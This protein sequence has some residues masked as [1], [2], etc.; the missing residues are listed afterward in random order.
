MRN[1]RGGPDRL[2]SVW[3]ADKKAFNGKQKVEQADPKMGGGGKN[4]PGSINLRE[5]LPACSLPAQDV[6]CSFL[7]F[8][9]DCT[10]PPGWRCII[11]NASPRS[12]H[13][14]TCE[15]TQSFFPSAPLLV[16]VNMLAVCLCA[17]GGCV[18]LSF[19][20]FS[21]WYTFHRSPSLLYATLYEPTN[22]TRPKSLAPWVM[23]P[24]TLVGTSRSTW[25]D[26][27]TERNVEWDFL[28]FYLFFAIQKKEQRNVP[29]VL[30]SPARSMCHQHIDCRR[31]KSG[32]P[33][34]RCVEQWGKVYIPD[35]A[36]QK[37]HAQQLGRG[38]LLHLS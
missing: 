25:R 37:A 9:P 11:Q 10:L 20:C 32:F 1:Q 7:S 24:V 31:Q 8:H 3:A 4:K 28:I 2:S 35:S 18:T 23:T 17:V 38:R 22:W 13:A 15:S 12:A 36:N 29:V 19:R 27:N 14:C 5:F 16:S 21:S 34:L 6:L 26:K 33:L 30:C